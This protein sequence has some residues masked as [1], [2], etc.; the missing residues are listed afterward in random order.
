MAFWIQLL[1]LALP[2]AALER[3]PALRRRRAPFFRPGLA[4]DALYLVTGYGAGASL[5]AAY[6]LEGSRWCGAALGIPRLGSAGLPLWATAP[7]ALL[8]LDLG[9]YGVHLLLHRVDALWELHKVH[10]SSPA[11]DWLATFRSHLLEQALRR[12]LAP[13]LLIL[14]GVPG[15]ALALAYGIFLAFAIANHANLAL[16]LRRLEPVFVT[17]RLHRLHHVPETTECNLGTVFS[18]WDRLRGTLVREETEPDAALGVPGELASYPQGFARQ[19]VEPL[20]RLLP[21]SAARGPT[22]ARRRASTAG[23]ARSRRSAP[24]SS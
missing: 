6:I 20:S 22:A 24:S 16:P 8:A 1:G 4:S 11:L 13:L 23:A 18:G 10:H 7:L 9:N 2:V 5:A 15:D 3:L 12:L 19:L 21:Q 17:P 14:L